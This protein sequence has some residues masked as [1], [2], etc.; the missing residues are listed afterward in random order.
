MSV[1]YSFLVCIGEAPSCDVCFSEKNFLYK[2]FL[3]KYLLCILTMKLTWR[4]SYFCLPTWE[5]VV[6]AHGGDILDWIRVKFDCRIPLVVLS[7]RF[8]PLVSTRLP[9]CE[10]PGSSSVSAF[11]LITLPGSDFFCGF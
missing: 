11:Y 2:L 7:F 1:A 4:Y 10:L 8:L 9:G 3:K 5:C 6:C